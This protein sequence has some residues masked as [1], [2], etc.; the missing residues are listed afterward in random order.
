MACSTP[1]QGA[2][3]KKWFGINNETFY[4]GFE[5]ARQRHLFKCLKTSQR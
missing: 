5:L 1:N 4:S 3:E 2:C